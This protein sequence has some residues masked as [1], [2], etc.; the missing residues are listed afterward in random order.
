MLRLSLEIASVSQMHVA[1]S[2]N[3]GTNSA[4]A[5]LSTALS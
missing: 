2:F 1:I 4:L 5:V 3:S